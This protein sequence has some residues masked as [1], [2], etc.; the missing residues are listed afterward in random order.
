M[1]AELV[2]ATGQFNNLALHAS[3]CKQVCCSLLH[4]VW[5]N[6]YHNACR[7]G[8]RNRS[9]QQLS[10]ACKSVQTGLLGACKFKFFTKK[11][12]GSAC[13]QLN[14]MDMAAGPELCMHLKTSHDI[15][16]KQHHIS[17][18]AF[19]S[20]EQENQRED[21]M[22]L[23]HQLHLGLLDPVRHAHSRQGTRSCETSCYLE[24]HARALQNY[25]K[26]CVEPER[27]QQAR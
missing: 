3:Q 12:L 6:S 7:A 22:H 24:L 9:V 5:L 15:V 21:A 23:R 20:C 13:V 4:D 8:A 11:Q 2:H 14:W 16:P 25:K 1:L 27:A 18:F 17:A 26:Q 10:L 19:L